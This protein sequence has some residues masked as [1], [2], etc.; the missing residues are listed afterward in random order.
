MQQSGM[1]G[2]A[3]GMATPG[4]MGR[5]SPAQA[6]TMQHQQSM[7]T[8]AMMHPSGVPQRVPAPTLTPTP[9]PLE[10]IPQSGNQNL[11]QPAQQQQQQTSQPAQSKELNAAS[12]CRFGQEAVSEIVSRAQEVFQ[13][14]RQTQ[15]ITC[16]TFSLKVLG[17]FKNCGHCLLFRSL[18]M[19][20]PYLQLW[21][22]NLSFRKL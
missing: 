8:G 19:E 13:T 14:L 5:Q 3:G 7:H 20:S 10:N 16:H 2:I 4:M 15:V 21:I 11:Q 22:G 1:S 9:T 6:Q 17:R 18:L 12:L